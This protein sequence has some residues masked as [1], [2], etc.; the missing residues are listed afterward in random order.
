LDYILNH[1][2]IVLVLA[3]VL[4]WL[5]AYAGDLLRESRRPA[6]DTAVLDLSV[7]VGAALSL[8]ALIIGFSFAM[9][10]DRYDQRKN[11]EEAEAN[12]IGTEYVRVDLLPGTAH[13]RELLAKYTKERILFY[14][15]SD[16]AEL[17]QISTVTTKLQNDLWSAVAGSA[18]TE[19]TPVAAL[20]LAGM[21]DV[22]NSQGY[23][24]AAW[25][26][27]VP[28]GAWILM[29]FVAMVCNVL[30][31][32]S[33]RRGVTLLVLP[34]IVSIPL[35]LIADMDSPRGG[36]IHVVPQNL[37]SLQQSLGGP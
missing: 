8:L 17:Q 3:F 7:I 15:S 23:T 14:R 27:R 34:V 24:Q 19:P 9:A 37:I 22:L 25:R 12:A 28:V 32:V 11:Y 29:F 2:P 13:V 35:F 5:A 31:G 16:L 30:L 10:I 21:N 1:P 33:E 18:R 20:V 26:N 4:Q 6:A 36:F